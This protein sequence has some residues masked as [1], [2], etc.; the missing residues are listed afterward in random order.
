MCPAVH[1]AAAAAA[2]ADLDQPEPLAAACVPAEQ[3]TFGITVA[4]I[5]QGPLVALAPRL[6]AYTQP[7]GLLGLSGRWR[8][9]RRWVRGRRAQL[10]ASAARGG[11]GG[12]GG[13][14]P[15]FYALDH[16]G[17]LAEQTPAVMDAY[18]PWFQDFEVEGEDRW[19][20]VTAVRRSDG[21]EAGL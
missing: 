12:A 5:L 1:L 17:I 20:L 15:R 19:A 14:T 10:R 7:G 4:N 11:G 21:R 6:A 18:R 8:R 2:A 13:G 3:R 9:W 16:A